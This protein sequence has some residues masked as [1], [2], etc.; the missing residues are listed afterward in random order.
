MEIACGKFE[1]YGKLD[2]VCAWYAKA[3]DFTAGTKIKTAYVST[4]SIC[5]GESVGI[6]W[7]P[8]FDRGIRI[9]FAYR[10]FI[11]DN[12]ATDKAHVHVVIVGFSY[13]TD[14]GKQI[15]DRESRMNAANINGYLLDAPDVFMVNRSGPLN[16]ELPQMKKGS[17]PT[18]GK[19]LLLSEEDAEALIKHFPQAASLIKPYMG[20]EE[21]ING[22][23][24]YCLWLKG[25]APEK[26]RNIPP[27]M[28]RLEQ[29]AEFRRNSP[30]KSV[31][32][33]AQTP[34]LFTQIRQPESPHFLCVPEVSSER[35]SYCQIV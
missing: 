35:R 6:L 33:A 17:Q 14:V 13:D 21:F 12:E 30:T 2:Y 9:N 28:Q 11:W 20:S 32:E 16:P 19:R 22:R 24:R 8:L 34:M 18:D 27:V 23:K 10:P 25:V 4:N 1:K 3:A 15:F 26:Y 5:Q 7:R 29:V 31:Q